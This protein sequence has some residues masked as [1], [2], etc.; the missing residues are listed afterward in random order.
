MQANLSLL[1]VVRHIPLVPVGS[2][3]ATKHTLLSYFILSG[4]FAK[5]MWLSVPTSTFPDLVFTVT[6]SEFTIGLLDTAFTTSVTTSPSEFTEYTLSPLRILSILLKPSSVITCVS[7]GKHW[8][9]SP[10]NTSVLSNFLSLPNSVT[11][12]LMIANCIL[13][14]SCASSMKKLSYIALQ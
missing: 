4:I 9:S 6:I 12:A 1:R 11:S 7:P 14:T 8:S 5:Q 2:T 3:N 13:L 10:I